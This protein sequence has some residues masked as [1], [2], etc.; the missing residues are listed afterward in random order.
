M[1]LNTIEE[2]QIQIGADAL[3]M[4]ECVRDFKNVYEKRPDASFILTPFRGHRGLGLL[5]TFQF[6]KY[7]RTLRKI[8]KDIVKATNSK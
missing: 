2:S 8:N 6:F 5:H 3:E 1:N 4:D 7:Y